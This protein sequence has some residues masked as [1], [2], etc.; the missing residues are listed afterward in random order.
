MKT[1]QTIHMELDRT[2]KGAHR[3]QEFDPKTKRTLS[4]GEDGCAIG[5]LYLRKSFIGGDLPEGTVIEVTV[6]KLKT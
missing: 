2:T 6:S 4:P 5:T 3:F 1:N